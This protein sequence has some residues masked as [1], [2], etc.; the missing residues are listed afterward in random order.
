MLSLRVLTPADWDLWRD[1]RLAALA[2]APHAFKSRLED[3]E[4]DGEQRWR[5]RLEDPDTYNIVVLLG[6][7]A[8]GMA[9]GIA[10]RGGVVELRSVWVGPKARG[11]G[12]GDYLVGAVQAW[13]VRAGAV[14]L[15]LAVI[16]GNESAIALYRRNGFVAVDEVGELLPDG[17][18]REQVMRKELG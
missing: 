7:A 4:E 2:E 12:V 13:A 5:S 3:W 14:A 17:E 6:G 18:T 8:V 9:S 1:V 11:R 15:K 16:P 10:G